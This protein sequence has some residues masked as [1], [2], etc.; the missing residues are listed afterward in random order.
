MTE[1]FLKGIQEALNV[2]LFSIACFSCLPVNS[3]KIEITSNNY[4]RRMISYEK[5]IF[6]CKKIQGPP[7]AVMLYQE[8]YRS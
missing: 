7:V 8:V 1:S 6:Y 3:W 2:E 4:I 5:I